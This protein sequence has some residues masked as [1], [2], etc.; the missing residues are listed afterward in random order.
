MRA[1]FTD[2]LICKLSSEVLCNCFLHMCPFHQSLQLIHQHAEKLIS[3]HLLD[4]ID[5]LALPILEGMTE[6]LGVE[7]H[8][9][10]HF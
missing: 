4:H 7:I 9:F 5:W 10:T 2:Y 1:I 3:I 6:A 8:F